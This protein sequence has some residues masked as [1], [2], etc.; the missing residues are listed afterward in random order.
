M[1]LRTLMEASSHALAQ[2]RVAGVHFKVAGFTNYL[3]SSRLSQRFRR[4]LCRKISFVLDVLRKSR[5]RGRMA[6]VNIDDLKGRA[7]GDMGWQIS[8]CIGNE[9]SDADVVALERKLS[10]TGSEPN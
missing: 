6:I 8:S 9:S 1:E 5:V 2:E 10:L 7:S 4:I 3:R